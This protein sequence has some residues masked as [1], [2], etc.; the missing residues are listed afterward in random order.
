MTPLPEPSE[1]E[2]MKARLRPADAHQDPAAG[3]TPSGTVWRREE[4][5]RPWRPAL[6]RR[7]ASPFTLLD[8]TGLNGHHDR[9]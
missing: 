1:W 2:A 6:I 9:R 8:R 5:I 4:A 7:H 3:Q